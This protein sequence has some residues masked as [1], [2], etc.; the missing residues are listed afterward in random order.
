MSV[1]FEIVRGSPGQ[2][3]LFL[4]GEHALELL[5][6]PGRHVGLDPKDVGETAVVA[7]G[8]EVLVPL[9]VDELGRDPDLVARPLDAAL[10]HAGHPQL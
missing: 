10:Q 9:R 1:G 6:D 8:P 7:L 5:D 3:G 2:L 4:G